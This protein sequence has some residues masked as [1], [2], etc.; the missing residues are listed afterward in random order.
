MRMEDIY[1]LDGV[2]REP[3]RVKGYFFGK[4]KK[5]ACVVGSMRGNEIQQLY[6]CSQLVKALEELEQAEA[7]ARKAALPPLEI[8]PLLEEKV[9]FD[10]FCKCDFRAV[11]V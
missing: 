2:Y 7:E 4:G 9:D 11:T 6:V 5:A 3:M 1:A 8:E 10:T